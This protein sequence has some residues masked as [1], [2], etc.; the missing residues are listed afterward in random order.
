MADKATVALRLIAP[1]DSNGNPRR[2]WAVLDE[3]GSV[4]RFVEE[5]YTG[6]RVLATAGFGEVVRGPEINV[7]AMEFRAWIRADR[8]RGAS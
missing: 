6:P 1:H 7:T 4:I 5:G 8:E 3:N 2:G